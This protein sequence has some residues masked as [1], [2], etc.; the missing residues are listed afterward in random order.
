MDTRKGGKVKPL[1][2]SFLCHHVN[3]LM[4]SNVSIVQ[5]WRVVCHQCIGIRKFHVVIRWIDLNK[6]WI[7]FWFV[8]KYNFQCNPVLGVPPNPTHISI[9]RNFRGKYHFCWF[10]CYWK[11]FFVAVAL[12][13]KL[14]CH[15]IVIFGAQGVVSNNLLHHTKTFLWYHWGAFIRGPK[16]P[17]SLSFRFFIIIR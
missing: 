11:S 9:N 4:L 10:T 7:K 15:K 17:Y 14:I 13:N 12:F 1:P 2:P 5:F 8:L 3:A 16:T 6:A